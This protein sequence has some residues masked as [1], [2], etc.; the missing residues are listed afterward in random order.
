M[1]IR[2]KK[3]FKSSETIFLAR[4]QMFIGTVMMVIGSMEPGIFAG[5]MGKWF[6][7]F[8]IG[9]GVLAEY[10][11]KRRDVDLKNRG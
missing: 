8:L 7:L 6:P 4:A 11:R 1:W 5:I 10:L 2:I 9:H 3:F